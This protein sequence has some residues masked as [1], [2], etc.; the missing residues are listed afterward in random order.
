MQVGKKTCG[1][2][3]RLRDRAS[4]PELVAAPKLVE[5]AVAQP[6]PIHRGEGRRHR[7]YLAFTFWINVVASMIW[8]P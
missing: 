8:M 2:F 7:F 1:G 5:G 4:A 6:V 3:G